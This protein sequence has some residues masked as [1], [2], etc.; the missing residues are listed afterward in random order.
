MQKSH[1]IYSHVAEFDNGISN[2]R[3]LDFNPSTSRLQANKTALAVSKSGVFEDR[4]IK[5]P[6]LVELP[7]NS[8]IFKSAAGFRD[9]KRHI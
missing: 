1:C 2:K 5:S 9:Y 8:G 6:V 4:H 7:L 3:L